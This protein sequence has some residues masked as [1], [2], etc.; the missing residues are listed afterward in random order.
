MENDKLWKHYLSL[1]LVGKNGFRG[2]FFTINKFMN[3]NIFV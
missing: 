1:V 2:V 3:E